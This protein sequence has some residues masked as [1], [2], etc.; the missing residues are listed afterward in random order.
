MLG[1]RYILPLYTFLIAFIIIE[2]SQSFVI[3]PEAPEWI[4]RKGRSRSLC[5]V[6][7]IVLI[8]GYLFLMSSNT[9]NPKRVQDNVASV[10]SQVPKEFY[11]EMVK[12]NLI[13]KDYLY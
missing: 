12:N 2:V 1:L 13:S 5:E 3:N 11:A 6:R 9:S 8:L 10:V 4:A 7:I